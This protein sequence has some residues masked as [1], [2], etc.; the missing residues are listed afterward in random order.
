MK[1]I[2]SLALGLALSAALSFAAWAADAK[3]VELSVP[4]MTCPVCPLTVK[5][6]LERV[7]GVQAAKVDFAS[8][9][10]VVEFDPKRVSVEQLTRA[11]ADAGYPSTMKKGSGS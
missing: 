1:K 4:G 9:S 7:P 3:R 5:K 6:A 10:A 11:T 8:R 2:V